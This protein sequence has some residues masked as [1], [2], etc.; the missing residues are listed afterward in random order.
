MNMTKMREDRRWA[1]LAC[2]GFALAFVGAAPP[3]AAVVNGTFDTLDMSN[4]PGF[5][6][7]QSTPS[8]P[9][10]QE[11]K[12]ATPPAAKA[13]A[14]AIPPPP[15]P[16][17][18]A[19]ALKPGDVAG[20]YSMQREGG[21]DTGCMLTLD[22]KTKAQ[23]GNKATLAPACRDQGIL[24]FDP[25]GWRLVGG[26]LVLIARRGHSTRLDL[27]ATGTWLKDPR[28]GKPLILKKM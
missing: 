18:A 22:N 28:E 26:R 25:A 20:R 4:A 13:K 21:K 6:V 5:E 23:G 15:K 2:F 3:E 12:S 19:L 1:C 9:A 10:T 11:A 27:Q 24:I 16:S 7:V 17:A 8:Q 14:P